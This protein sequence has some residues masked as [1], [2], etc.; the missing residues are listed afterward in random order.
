MTIIHTGASPKS[1]CTRDQAEEITGRFREAVGRVESVWNVVVATAIEAYRTRVW[2][3][4]DYPSWDSYCA[5]EVN[6]AAA[7]IPRELRVQIVGQMSEAGLSTR[8][9][10]PV[11]GAN[12]ST[13]VRDIAGGANAPREVEPEPATEPESYWSP[14]DSFVG[15]HPITGEI[16]ENAPTTFTE[17]HT[18][19]T[20]TGL[21]GK[22]YKNTPTTP[23]RTSIIDDARNAGW[24]LRK[25][26]ERL[27]RLTTDDRFTK[28]K[29]EILAA[30][31]PHLDF[32]NEVFSDL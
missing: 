2:I 19:K 22:E 27:E 15:A 26:A 20:V 1:E 30:L 16:I 11:V 4:L 14:E 5:A 31:Q 17:T 6:E 24:A 21:D 8:A 3:P 7:R 25:A 9:I 18:I 12:H 13:V 10:A 29:V 28:N 23:R 32:A